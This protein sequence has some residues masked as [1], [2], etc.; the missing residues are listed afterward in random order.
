[1]DR[2]KEHI[3]LPKK[4][5]NLVYYCKPTLDLVCDLWDSDFWC[6][7]FWL[8]KKKK[9]TLQ[10]YSY[11]PCEHFSHLNKSWFYNSI[12]KKVSSILKDLLYNTEPYFNT[13]S[14]VNQKKY[15][16]IIVIKLVTML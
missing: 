5:E 2:Y 9:K 7:I 13:P 11:K 12:L 16:L 14:I 6:L 8:E 3:Q 4:Y 15:S 10:R 1:M